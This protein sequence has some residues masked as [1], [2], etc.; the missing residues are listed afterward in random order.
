MKKIIFLLLI[1]S[2]FAFPFKKKCNYFFDKKL[3]LLSYLNSSFKNIPIKRIENIDWSKE[4]AES[5]RGLKGREYLNYLKGKQA[6]FYTSMAIFLSTQ[7]IEEADKFIKMFEDLKKEE[8]IFLQESKNLPI[9]SSYRIG[10]DKKNL[11]FDYTS[12]Y[13]LGRG[14][15]K[16]VIR[17]GIEEIKNMEDLLVIS[18]KMIDFYTMINF[19]PPKKLSNLL[20][21]KIPERMKQNIELI[22]QKLLFDYGMLHALGDDVL[23]QYSLS[24]EFK[25]F[26]R[27]MS[28]HLIGLQYRMFTNQRLSPHTWKIIESKGADFLREYVKLTRGVSLGYRYVSHT[29]SWSL[30]LVT[31]GFVVYTYLYL[32]KAVGIYQEETTLDVSSSGEKYSE[33]Q[34]IELQRLVD[35]L[36][37]TPDEFIE[38]M[39]EEFQNNSELLMILDSV[40]KE[41][42]HDIKLIMNNNE[43]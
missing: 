27:V 22:T 28:T 21:N 33:E 1:N 40:N 8:R 2:V 14:K 43:E 35:E 37:L 17:W 10:R 5:L 42:K 31:T 19:R 13:F 32:K 34:S 25:E 24:S 16:T 4:L 9:S 7:S 20:I 38:E 23:D 29:I 6:D 30:F 26:M 18:Q 3:T 39:R 15:G 36:K 41:F 11:L 12:R